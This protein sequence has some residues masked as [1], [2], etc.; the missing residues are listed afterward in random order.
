MADSPNPCKNPLVWLLIAML[1]LWGCQAKTTETVP[2]LKLSLAVAPAPYSGLIAVADE[3]GYFREAGLEVSIEDYPSGKDALE[4]VCRGD[5]QAATTSDLAFSAKAQ[6]RSIIAR[7]WNFDP[8]FLVECWPRTRLN[9]I[10]NQSIVISLQ[11]DIH[12]LMKKSGKSK[13]SPP[14]VLMYLHTGVLD[15]VAPDLV[16]IYR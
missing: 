5:A 9:V 15:K 10:F 7:K 3:M 11:N 13:D 12:W 16:T 4:A 14:D 6:T 8:A 2:P 1:G